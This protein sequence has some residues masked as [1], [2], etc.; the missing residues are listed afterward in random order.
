MTVSQRVVD[1]LLYF[2][3]VSDI[4]ITVSYWM[5]RIVMNKIAVVAGTVKHLHTKKCVSGRE[6]SELD[7]KASV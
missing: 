2:V 3:K 1:T 6:A 5:H 4:T 7:E